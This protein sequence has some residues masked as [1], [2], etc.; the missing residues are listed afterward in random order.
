MELLER[1][2]KSLNKSITDTKAI[3][4][5]SHALDS[6]AASLLHIAKNINQ[7]PATVSD[8]QIELIV[9]RLLD[10]AKAPTV[11]AAKVKK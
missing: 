10:D 7:K 1:A 3:S 6:I 5:Q 9:R 4:A 2:R 11:K 8:D